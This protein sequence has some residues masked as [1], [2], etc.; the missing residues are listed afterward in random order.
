MKQF[1]RP[2]FIIGLL[3]LLNNAFAGNP[4]RQGEAG[5][6]ELLMNPWARS[7]G[8]HTLTTANIMGVEALQLNVAGLARRD[9]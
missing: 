2:F 4:D 3:L 6:Y 1:L 7:A 8:L 9:R 5:A